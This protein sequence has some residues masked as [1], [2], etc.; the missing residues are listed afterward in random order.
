MYPFTKFQPNSVFLLSNDRILSNIDIFRANFSAVSNLTP[1]CPWN[2]S[3]RSSHERKCLPSPELLGFTR[4]FSAI[5]DLF[6]FFLQS[7]FS[8]ASTVYRKN[9][10][11]K[12]SE[13]W[14]SFISKK[15][16]E[17]FLYRCPLVDCC[18]TALPTGNLTENIGQDAWI[19]SREPTYPTL[20]IG[21]SSSKCHF[22]GIC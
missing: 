4:F 3:K 5:P 10:Y 13:K 22:W 12:I 7:I 11:I 20:G 8:I 18:T 1:K 15:P 19:P 2:H 14:S 9:W 17:R 16:F 21:K 6:A